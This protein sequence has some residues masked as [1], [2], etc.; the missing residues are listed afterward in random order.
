MATTPPVS[1]I[2][3]APPPPPPPPPPTPQPPG[4]TWLI[5]PL[6][7]L[8]GLGIFLLW[9][10][11]YLASL[12]A[13]ERFTIEGTRLILVLTLIV[14][15]LGFGGLMIAR[16]LYGNL[17]SEDLNARYR[18]AREVFLVFAGTFGTVTGFY[19]GSAGS[20]GA[21]AA[22]LVVSSSFAAGKVTL[23]VEGGTAP[24]IAILQPAG[25]APGISLN[26]EQRAI[27]LPVSGPCPAK[28]RV[29]VVD[30][31]GQRSETTIDCTQPAAE[32]AEPANTTAPDNQAEEAPGN[33][34]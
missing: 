13:A 12:P 26:S 34:G 1:S 7:L 24:F 10:S 18:L 16:S 17:S 22:A 20:N 15:M 33:Q 9:V 29:T 5:T 28:A 27:S 21:P 19:F 11:N 30:G 25:D 2:P 3:T 4:W 32:P 31:R 23:S 6:T 8:I 14:S